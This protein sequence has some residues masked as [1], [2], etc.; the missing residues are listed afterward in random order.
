MV[1]IYTGIIRHFDKKDDRWEPR[2]FEIYDNGSMNMYQDSKHQGKPTIVFKLKE[3][4]QLICIGKYT[5]NCPGK[6]WH[7]SLLK[8][9]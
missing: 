7:R 3:V 4:Q 9:S 5:I 6:F 2:Y 1:E 8:T